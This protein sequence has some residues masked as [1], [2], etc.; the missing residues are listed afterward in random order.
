MDG[1]DIMDGFRHV[2]VHPADGPAVFPLG[3]QGPL[4]E[5]PGKHK[6]QGKQEAED[7]EQPPAPAP[8]D[9]QDPQQL[10]GI[11][12]HPYDA[13]R[14]QGI[15]GIPVIDEHR[16]GL[17]AGMAG[18]IPGRQPVQLG[19]Q[20]GPESV[21][22][23]LSKYGDGPVLG[24]FEAVRQHRKAEVQHRQLPRDPPAFRQA[25]HRPF[26]DQRRQKRGGHG[27]DHQHCHQGPG[28]RMGPESPFD[29]FPH[30]ILPIHPDPPLPAG[31]S[32]AGHSRAPAASV[33]H[34]SRSFPIPDPRTALR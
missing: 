26:Q 6:K 12:Q 29:A 7:Q 25:V 1:P 32:P 20:G 24:R 8:Q 18:K 13:V 9:P 5:M 15:D 10:A 28:T 33:P 4:L 17:A 2:A 23:L 14:I 30:R 11:G 27:K 19:T 3:G 16:G 34:G 31:A 21:G 22:H